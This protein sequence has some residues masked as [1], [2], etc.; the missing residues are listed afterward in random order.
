MILQKKKKKK[1]K[2]T[3]AL[4]GINIVEK[5]ITR[6][7]THARTRTH[8]RARTHTHTHT[9]ARMQNIRTHAYTNTQTESCAETI[10]GQNDI[11]NNDTYTR[12]IYNISV[13][14]DFNQGLIQLLE[15][16]HL[17]TMRSVVL[18]W[19]SFECNKIER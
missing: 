5:Q 11:Y 6:A 7:R 18:S 3:P 2:L 8:A 15:L 17:K 1:K 12:K 13:I 14:I 16:L 10:I 4:S 19:S 9:C